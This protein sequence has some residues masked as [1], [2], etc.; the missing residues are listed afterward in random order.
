MNEIL[1]ST[2]HSLN[3]KPVDNPQQSKE[4]VMENYRS[5][6]PLI[7]HNSQKLEEYIEK[8]SSATS[9]LFSHVESPEMR[10]DVAN[11]LSERTSVISHTSSDA[12]PRNISG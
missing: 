1:T 12:T 10:T 9:D 4:K 7:F 6:S 3:N 2:L 11:D 8:F 5:V